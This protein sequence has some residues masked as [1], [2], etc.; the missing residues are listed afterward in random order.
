MKKTKIAVACQGGGSETA[1]TAGVLKTLFDNNNHHQKDIIGLT[2]TSG[3]DLNAALAWYG[4]LKAAK[5]DSTPI[6]KRITDFWQDLMAQESLEIFFDQTLMKTLRLI[7]AG[8]LPLFEV[9]PA[10][11]IGHLMTSTVSR[12]LPRERFTNFKRLLEDH[13]KFE[14]IESLLEPTSPVLLIGAANV[15]K[16]NLKIFSS[17]NG[18]FRVETIIASA[19]IPNFFQ[20]SRLARI[21]IGMAYFRQIP[22]LTSWFK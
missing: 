3:G 20:P 16:G 8:L 22:P 21:T 17:R 18:E 19:A 4:L 13:I 11:F 7:N 14:E 15:L 9:S 10:S 1:F 6:G 5:G 12:F 2:G